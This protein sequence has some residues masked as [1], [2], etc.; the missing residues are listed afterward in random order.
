M[1]EISDTH[2]HPNPENPKILK[3]LIRP[4]DK[5][6]AML[7]PFAPHQHPNPENLEN[8]LN[9]DSHDGMRSSPTP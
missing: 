1:I 8:P 4:L 5:M 6:L 3:I 9:P 2:Q 7:T